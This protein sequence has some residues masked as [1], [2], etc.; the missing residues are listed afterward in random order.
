VT[1]PPVTGVLIRARNMPDTLPA[2]HSVVA[3]AGTATVV[4]VVQTIPPAD[5]APGIM[6]VFCGQH[7]IPG[8]FPLRPG[9]VIK[10]WATEENFEVLSAKSEAVAGVIINFHAVVAP[11]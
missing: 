4:R 3:F 1:V 10:R 8:E 6:G 11:A 9:D 2:N 5:D 7:S